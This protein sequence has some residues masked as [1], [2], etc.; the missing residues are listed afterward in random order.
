MIVNVDPELA[1]IRIKIKSFEIHF[2]PVRI[3]LKNKNK[4]DLFQLYL[5]QL[6]FQAS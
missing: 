1:H 3:K 5:M 2:Y 6:A 4:S